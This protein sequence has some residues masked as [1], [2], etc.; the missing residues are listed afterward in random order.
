MKIGMV[1]YLAM[2]I[3]LIVALTSVALAATGD[4]VVTVTVDYVDLLAVPAATA[5][6]LTTATAGVTA[7]DQGTALD[8]DGFL[9]SHNSTSAKKITATAVLDSGGVNDVTL[10]AAIESGEAAAN[11]VTAGTVQSGVLLYTGI[12]AGGYTKDISW[13]AD[14]TL[15]GT[16][17]GANVDNDYVWTI[18]FTSAD[19]V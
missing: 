5:L 14:G 4:D 19:A 8:T 13:T 1:G 7:Y 3:F 12:G 9:Y 2:C 18:T 6:T 16:K 15:S 17:A 11:L 10:T